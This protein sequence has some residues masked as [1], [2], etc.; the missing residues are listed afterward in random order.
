MLYS[1]VLPNVLC[2][3]LCL[4]QAHVLTTLSDA[5]LRLVSAMDGVTIAGDLNIKIGSFVY[6]DTDASGG[7]FALNT[8]TVR[9]HYVQT[10][11]T[12]SA[13]AF[14]GRAAASMVGHGLSADAAATQINAL[15]ASGAYNMNADVVQIAFPNAGLDSR[16][17]PTVNIGSVTAGNATK[18][19]GALQ[20]R[21]FDLQGTTT[22]SWPH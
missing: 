22:W 10:I 8:V 7:A 21:H 4:P 2:W 5:D 1:R 17:A 13:S 3:M 12:L 15:V 16:L 9:G 11:D 19:I 20:L 6:L 18:S 14:T